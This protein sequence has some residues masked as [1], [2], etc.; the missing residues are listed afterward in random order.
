MRYKLQSPVRVVCP[1]CGLEARLVD[2]KEV[3]GKSRGF[4]PLWFC[5]C[6]PGGVYVGCHKGTTLPLGTLANSRLRYWRMRAH[7]AFDPLHMGKK[8]AMSRTEAYQWLASRLGISVDD[9][10]IAMFDEERCQTVES[11]CQMRRG[12]PDFKRPIGPHPKENEE[13]QSHPPQVKTPR[14]KMTALPED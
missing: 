7:R 1:Y 14:P 6:Q 5:N 12:V 13:K 8:E 2:E 10:H 9:C 11:L 4:G 3:Y